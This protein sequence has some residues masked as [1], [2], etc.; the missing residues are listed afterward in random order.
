MIITQ[1]YIKCENTGNY[2]YG[3][4]DKTWAL[5]ACY[6]HLHGN[7]DLDYYARVWHRTI[8]TTKLSV[9][10]TNNRHLQEYCDRLNALDDKFNFVVKMTEI[11]Y[12]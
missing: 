2:F 9:W 5:S 1:Y 6:K 11:E 4:D 10:S 3:G 8:Q 12:R 7:D